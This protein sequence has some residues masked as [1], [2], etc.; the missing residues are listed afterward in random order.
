MGDLP[1]GEHVERSAAPCFQDAPTGGLQARDEA[2]G[3]RPEGKLLSVNTLL[4]LLDSL[5]QKVVPTLL[6]A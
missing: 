5:I 1:G 3:R 2:G 6:F 4:L